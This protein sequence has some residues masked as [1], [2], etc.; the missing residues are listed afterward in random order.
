MSAPAISDDVRRAARD[1]VALMQSGEA[2]A[3]DRARLQAWLA[4]DRAHAA[5]FD[6]V[7]GVWREV[8]AMDELKAMIPP[9]VAAPGAVRRW[10]APFARP[11]VPATLAACLAVV[12]V[13][14]VWRPFDTAVTVPDGRY[15]TQTGEVRDVTLADGS[16][17]TLDARSRI[18]VA[19]DDITRR[20]TLVEGTAF[21]AVKADPA[22]PFHVAAGPA[23]I[24]VVGTRFDVRRGVGQVRVSVVEGVVEVSQADRPALHTLT[25]GQE[26]VAHRGGPPTAVRAVKPSEQAAWRQGRL[27]FNDVRLREVVADAN[28]YYRGEIVLADQALGDLGV[29]AAFNADQI[30]QLIDSVAVVLDLEA[31][32]YPDGRV[33]LRARADRG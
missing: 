16:T 22:R 6:S 19:F 1:W 2:T 30:D 11:A 28:R 15:A 33:I 8:A 26:M 5:A 10:F 4:A 20:V 9:D 18:E 27:V 7:S 3:G 13:L 14:V 32:R 23:L 31:L 21:F 24:R 12:A 17:V 25:A 29:T